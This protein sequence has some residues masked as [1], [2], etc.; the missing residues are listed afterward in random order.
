[1]GSATAFRGA[2]YLEPKAFSLKGNIFARGV[3][4]SASAFIAIVAFIPMVGYKVK[5]NLDLCAL[6]GERAMRTIAKKLIVP[7]PEESK[8]AIE[9]LG[10]LPSNANKLHLVKLELPT[11]SGASQS[12]PLPP[13]VVNLLVELLRQTASG[14]AVSVLPVRKE[15]TTQDAAELLNV[16]RPFVIGLLQKG[17]IPF[18][19]VGS[20]RRIPLTALLAYKHKTDAARDEALDFLAAQA[21]ELK[22]GY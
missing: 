9:A 16:S 10:A 3:S 11:S 7:T 14:N 6:A 2:P 22:L 21:Q 13:R 18:R 17:E 1:V 4:P 19:M 5:T 12:V 20:H 8:L 15:V